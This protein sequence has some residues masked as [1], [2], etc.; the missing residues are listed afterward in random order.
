VQNT[1]TA[2]VVIDGLFETIIQAVL[3]EIHFVLMGYLKFGA[4]GGGGSDE[5][6]NFAVR[7]SFL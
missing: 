5:T 6:E 1:A 3:D 2:T 7:W 4:E